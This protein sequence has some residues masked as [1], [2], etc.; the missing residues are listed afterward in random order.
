MADFNAHPIPEGITTDQALMLTDNLPS[1]WFGCVNANIRPGAKVGVVGLG[2]IG[3]M[4]VQSCFIL[5]ASEV[6]AIDLLPER[7]AIAATLG[8]TPVDG[9]NALEVIAE[10]TKGQ[11]LDCVV[12]AVG[13]D[14][15]IKM[16]LM[17]AGKRGHVSAIGVTQTRDFAFPMG[18][19]FMKG[20]TFPL[21]TCS[22]QSPWP[23][24]L[25]LLRSGRTPPEKYRK[26]E[27]RR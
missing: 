14:A 1:A 4:A 25:P 26:H 3:L 2:P 22:G 11:G 15:T 12:E 23:A 8:A 13:A 5:G 9:A 18:L 27:L 19:A 24:L 7:R 6:F 21:G 10:A 20:L 17:L 16:A